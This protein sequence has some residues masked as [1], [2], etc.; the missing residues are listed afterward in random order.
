MAE[1]L[2]TSFHKKVAAPNGLTGS[3]QFPLALRRFETIRVI[4]TS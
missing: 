4:E 3:S 1:S 2:A